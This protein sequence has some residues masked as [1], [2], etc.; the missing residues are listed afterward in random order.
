MEENN[1]N[2]QPQPQPQY[3]ETNAVM[4]VG[5]YIVMFILCAIPV[6]NIICW[7]VW[8]CSS[9]TNKNKKNY[10]IANIILWVIAIVI[11][12]VFYAVA[13]TAFLSMLQ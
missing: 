5:Q 8:L 12:V 13:G 9:K 6:V 11:S 4:S 1:Y 3:D 7:I 2:Y 10:I